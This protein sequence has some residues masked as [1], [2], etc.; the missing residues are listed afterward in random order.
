MNANKQIVMDY[1]SA[2]GSRDMDALYKVI[3]RDAEIWVPEGTRFSGTY[4]PETYLKNLDENVGPLLNREG[5]Q[6]MDV[7][8]MTAEEDR[9][10]VESES[11]IDLKNG[12]VYNNKYHLM[13]RIRDGLI[14]SVKEYL[15]TQHVVDVLE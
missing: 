2:L 4:V 11:Y 15:N 9:V 14:V 12:K 8:S 5:T 3:A 13:F 10:S 6:K 7:L 1:F